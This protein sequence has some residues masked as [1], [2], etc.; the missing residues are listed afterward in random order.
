MVSTAGFRY[1]PVAAPQMTHGAR[2]D[3][4]QSQSTPSLSASRGCQK[5]P[6]HQHSPRSSSLYSEVAGACMQPQ[7]LL[8]LRTHLSLTLQT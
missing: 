8:H 4:E 1:G 3:S 5:C 2:F 7:N 6:D